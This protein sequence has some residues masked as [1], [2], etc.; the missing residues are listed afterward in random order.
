MDVFIIEDNGINR[1][2]LETILEDQNYNITGSFSNAEE[3][4]ESL[5]NIS[6]DIVLIDINLAGDKDGIWLATNIRRHLNLPF[7]FLTAYGDSKT[8]ERVKKTKPNGYLMK[9]F[10]EPTLLTTIGI[11]IEEFKNKVKKNTKNL[12]IKDNYIRVKLNT[13]DIFYIKSEGNYLEIILE[14]KKHLIRSRITD[15]LMDLPK[16]SFIQIHR[17]YIVNIQKIDLL[18]N[19]FIKIKNVEIPITKTFKKDFLELLNL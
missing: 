18:G 15:F 4:W 2:S 6:T 9:P 14:N 1:I 17:R 12:Y 10:N 13:S 8:I 5:K 7:I 11:A 16:D 3:A 19:D